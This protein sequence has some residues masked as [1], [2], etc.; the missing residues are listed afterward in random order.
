VQKKK[1]CETA[2]K[3]TYSREEYIHGTTN[4]KNV[5][6]YIFYI[7]VGGEGQCNNEMFD[8]KF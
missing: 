6:L 3:R 4:K 2:E 8:I 5:E 1:E 7:K